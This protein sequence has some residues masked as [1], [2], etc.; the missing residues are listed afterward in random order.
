MHVLKMIQPRFQWYAATET[1]WI[2]SICTSLKF[3]NSQNDFP[4]YVAYK[5]SQLLV[6]KTCKMFIYYN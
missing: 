5:E 3:A 2:Q 1:I 6:S 4:V